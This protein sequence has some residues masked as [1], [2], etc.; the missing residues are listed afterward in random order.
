[1][2]AVKLIKDRGGEFA[3]I[4]MLTANNCFWADV[5]KHYRNICYSFVP[6]SFHYFA[7][8]C[9]H[10][11]TDTCRDK[12]VIYIRHWIQ[13]HIVSVGHLLGPY[14]YFSYEDFK[15]KYPDAI[16]N[17]MLYEGTVPS[18]THYQ[19]E[20]GLELEENCNINETYQWKYMSGC[21][22]THIYMHFAKNDDVPLKCI[23]KWSHELKFTF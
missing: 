23:E 12:K 4:L 5:F 3:N 7:A 20:L 13:C 8:E 11:N 19:A 18:V 15:A 1:M 22:N 17:L 21:C 14:R 2:M 9:L 16:V 6:V 10:Y